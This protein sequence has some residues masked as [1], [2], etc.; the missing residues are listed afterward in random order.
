[1]LKPILISIAL[2][3]PAASLAAPAESRLDLPAMN[4]PSC[5]VT[6]RAALSQLDGIDRVRIDAEARRVTVQYDD[7]QLS[8]ARIR[9]LLA[10]AGYPADRN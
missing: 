5:A 10:D 6:V 9:Q 3:L 1:M 2:L 7:A 4:C 8:E